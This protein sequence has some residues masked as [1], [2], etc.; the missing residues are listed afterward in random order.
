MQLE[1]QYEGSLEYK[2]FEINYTVTWVRELRS[3]YTRIESI[4][5]VFVCEDGIEVEGYYNEH[6]EEIDKLI[7][8]DAKVP[9]FDEPS[10]DEVQEFY[11]ENGY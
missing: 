1:Q 5:E 9:V 4:D 11:Y 7:K 10:A 2:N 3:S 8:A 6:R